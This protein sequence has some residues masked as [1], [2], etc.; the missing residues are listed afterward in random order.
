[1][2]SNLDNNDLTS[3]RKCH[4]QCLPSIIFKNSQMFSKQK[5]QSYFQIIFFKKINAWGLR[6]IRQDFQNYLRCILRG[7]IE[8]K[9]VK[10]TRIKGL[11]TKTLN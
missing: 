11:K 2:K 9:L 1:M 8:N 6:C 4:N 5:F 10:V 7:T 3:P